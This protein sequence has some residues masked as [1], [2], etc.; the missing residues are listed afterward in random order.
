MLD[1]AESSRGDASVQFQSSFRAVSEFLN[2]PLKYCACSKLE[3]E[4]FRAQFKGS[5]SF[6]WTIEDYRAFKEQFQII[7]RPIYLQFPF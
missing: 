5:S 1:G 4:S 6:N 7:L 2:G 3:W